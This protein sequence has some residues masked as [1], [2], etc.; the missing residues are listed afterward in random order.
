MFRTTFSASNSPKPLTPTLVSLLGGLTLAAASPVGAVEIT[1]N[2][3]SGSADRA[4]IQTNLNAA[5]VGSALRLVPDQQSQAGSAFYRQGLPVNPTT[6]FSTDFTFKIT[7]SNQPDLRSDG[8]AFVVQGSGP[9]FLGSAGES[10]GYR[11]SGS[12][13][14]PPV[15]QGYF[16]AVE[17]DT[18]Y[19]GG[20]GDRSDNEVAI[21]RTRPGD[22]RLGEP[23]VVTE[24]VDSVDLG[25]GP[26]PRPLLDNGELKNVRIEY[27][28]HNQAKVLSVFLSEGAGITPQLVLRTV[29]PDDLFH[30]G[31]AST[32]LGF[33]AATG[34][35][36]A[37][38]DILSWRFNVPE[39]G[40]L[41]LFG[42]AGLL[43]VAGRRKGKAACP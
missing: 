38:H 1:F 36:F 40:A 31:G 35:G 18:H 27:G 28:F 37:N 26:N 24:V 43:L 7:S 25:A 10:L 17:F 9:G 14:T 16:Y 2:D 20:T 21:T 3:F 13:P 15:T 34:A 29:L 42:I 33:T 6:D 5:F 41:S 30:F 4:L 12:G 32:Y 23:A 8:L 39:P 11:W 19:N 22:S